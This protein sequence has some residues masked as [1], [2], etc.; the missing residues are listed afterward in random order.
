MREARILSAVLLEAIPCANLTKRKFAS[1]R[2]GP[3]T[4]NLIKHY[5][6]SWVIAR[7]R[8]IQRLL[9]SF[10][11]SGRDLLVEATLGTLHRNNIR[12]VSLSNL[13]VDGEL[14]G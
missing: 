5:H 10:F 7:L 13:A 6:F 9:S 8:G 14:M 12:N 3:E 11:V 1:R 4:A 2:C